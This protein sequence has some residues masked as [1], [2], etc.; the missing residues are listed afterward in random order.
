MPYL[1]VP[2]GR[3]AYD[4]AGAG[5]LVVAV[6]GLGDVRSL[7]RFLVPRLVDTGYRV[8]TLDVRGHGESSVG[9][10]DYSPAAIGRDIVALL[11]HL[12]AGP[13]VL[14]GESMAAGSAV[15]AAA[16]APD[17]AAGIALAGPAVRDLP[18][19]PVARLGA[20]AVG[21]SARLWAMYYKS[22]YKTAPPPDLDAYLRALRANLAEPGRMAALRGI[23]A[24]PKAD[25]TARLEAV[26]CPALVL[27]GTKDPD[28]PDPAAEARWVAERLH[29]T[30][31]MVEGA[32]HYPPAEYPEQTAAALLPFLAEVHSGA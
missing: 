3:L 31:V 11:H 28:F 17:L 23:L 7:Y 30:T 27:M 10:D 8:V 26:R 19:N 2:G 29:A 12:D 13:A 6:P 32:G 4:S 20:W 22:L 21:R 16:E 1:D 9:W 24:A 14:I 18:M 5:P 25:C 15:Y